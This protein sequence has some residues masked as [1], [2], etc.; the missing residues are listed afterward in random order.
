MPDISQIEKI[1]HITKLDNPSNLKEIIS[2]KKAVFY[3]NDMS[4]IFQYNDKNVSPTDYQKTRDFLI[5]K[6]NAKS[7]KT[8]FI[9]KFLKKNFN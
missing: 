2:H 9:Y 5:L 4:N 6:E 8:S 3:N 7:Y 1:Y